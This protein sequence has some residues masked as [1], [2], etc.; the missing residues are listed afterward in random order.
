MGRLGLL[1]PK[2]A[3][4]NERSLQVSRIVTGRREQGGVDCS[5]PL[6]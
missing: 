4:F 3:D 1:G 5:L 2:I 6:Y